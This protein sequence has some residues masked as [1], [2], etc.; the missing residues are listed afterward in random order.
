MHLAL[1][2]LLFKFR[3]WGLWY[4]IGW[5]TMLQA[6]S[7]CV[8]FLMR[9]LNCSIDLILPAALWPWVRLSLYQKWVS[10]I[11]LWV[12]GSRL[13][14]LAMWPPFLCF[15]YIKCGSLK[16]SQCYS[17]PP[18]PP[19]FFIIII[20]ISKQTSCFTHSTTDIHLCIYCAALNG[21]DPYI[22]DWPASCST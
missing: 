13:V 17:P 21:W 1:V 10:G 15:L 4:C 19:D 2:S 7:L 20:R 14:R 6:G 5:D 9:S 3:Y 18:P 11:S 16:I 12:K 8:R 22:H